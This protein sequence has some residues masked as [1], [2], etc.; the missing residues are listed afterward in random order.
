MFKFTIR[1]L[2][3]LTLVVA[4]SIAWR[5]ECVQHAK[6]QR[7]LSDHPQLLVFHTELEA[8]LLEPGERV[9][10][11]RVDDALYRYFPPSKAPLLQPINIR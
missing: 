10:V 8:R 5:L 6:T 11:E 3:L 1:E 4:M 2:V 9:T 7:L